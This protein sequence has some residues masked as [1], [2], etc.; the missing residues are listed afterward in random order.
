MKISLQ[1]LETNMEIIAL[2]SHG[3]K[4]I[5]YYKCN[6]NKNWRYVIEFYF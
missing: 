1:C 5:S 2:N 3:G 6:I 4:S